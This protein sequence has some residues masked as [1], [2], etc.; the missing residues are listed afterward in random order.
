[1]KFKC[2]HFVNLTRLLDKR[3]VVAAIA[4]A[5]LQACSGAL[6]GGTVA[7]L[8][9]A[10][11]LP[12]LTDGASMSL[13]LDPARGGAITYLNIL[14]GD[15]GHASGNIV[16]NGDQVGRQMQAALYDGSSVPVAGATFDPACWPAT[17]ASC[18]WGNDPVQAGNADEVGS[19]GQILSQS[20]TAITT[21]TTPLQWDVR[22]GRSQMDLVQ[23]VAV[24]SPGVVRIDYRV[25]NL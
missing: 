5:G 12:V 8:K 10:V 20:A 13:E 16:D 2:E 18:L 7:S 24:I 14:D 1:M 25:T 19:G 9:S 17:G 6:A 3:V 4:L 11:P 15:A 23:T 21:Q 22:R